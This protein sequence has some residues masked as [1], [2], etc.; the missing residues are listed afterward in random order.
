MSRE[1]QAAGGGGG[2][3]GDLAEMREA[4]RKAVDLQRKYDADTTP[5]SNIFR[6]NVQRYE[7][8]SKKHPQFLPDLAT[9]KELLA[10][11][12]A[13]EARRAPAPQ[14]D[15]SGTWKFTAL[16]NTSSETNGYRVH[17]DDALVGMLVRVG[18]ALTCLSTSLEEDET[19]PTA[20]QIITAFARAEQEKAKPRRASKAVASV[21]P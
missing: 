8:L 16:K 19:A 1:A 6:E 13:E 18:E 14:R 15:I 4:R 17:L 12:L 2:D 9:A 3:G 5:V 21:T 20:D 11:Q 7:T 10:S